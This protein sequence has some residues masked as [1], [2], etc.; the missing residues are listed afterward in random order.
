MCQRVKETV[1]SGGVVVAT[2]VGS[3]VGEGKAVDGDA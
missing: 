1:G 3:G 2:V